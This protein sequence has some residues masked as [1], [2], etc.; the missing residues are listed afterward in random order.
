MTVR[1]PSPLLTGLALL[2]LGGT[3]AAPAATYTNPVIDEDFP[4]PFILRVGK[5][6]Y[7]Y[8]TNAGGLDVP[9]RRSSDLVHWTFVGD[10]LGGLGAW[11]SGGF[12]WAPE[13]ARTPKG[14]VLYYTARHT[15]SGR[16]CIG[17]A[18]SANPEG[19]F[20]DASAAPLVC[21]LDLGGSIDASPFTD[22]DGQRYLYWKND[23]NCCNQPTALWGQKLSADGLKLVGQPKDLLY[24][25]ALWEGNLIEAPQVYTRANKYYLFYSASDYNSDLYGVGYALGMSPLGP[26]RKQTRDGA[27]LA[28]KGKV[29][30]PGGQGV[31]TDGKGNTWLYYHAWTTGQVGYGSGGARSLRLD[32]LKFVNG[33]PM[34]KGPSVTAQPAPA[35]P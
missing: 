12:T 18:F 1:C 32:P 29:A 27:W 9:V 7:A 28:T 23:G 2:L 24:N 3:G 30:G 13:V 8:G 17:A 31:I 35:K 25:G 16:Q 26:F 33:L 14:Y 21:Q 10:A 11:A 4:D 5:A 6:Y 34:L 22:R 19:P 20:R 15:A